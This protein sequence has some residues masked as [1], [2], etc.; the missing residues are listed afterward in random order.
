MSATREQL[1]SAANNIREQHLGMRTC[2]GHAGF[3]Q[4]IAGRL[5]PIAVLDESGRTVGHIRG[6]GMLTTTT[7][8]RILAVLH[9]ARADKDKFRRYYE[10]TCGKEHISAINTRSEI[11]EIDAAVLEVEALPS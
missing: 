4:A 11:A 8:A 1:A 5:G 3:L 6:D 10:D 9:D 7:R 2:G